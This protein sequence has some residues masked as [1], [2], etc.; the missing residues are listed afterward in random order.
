MIEP[1]AALSLTRFKLILLIETLRWCH[2]H[3][4]AIPH[5]QRSMLSHLESSSWQDSNPRYTIAA[6]I[7]VVATLAPTKTFRNVHT[8][9]KPD[10]IRMEEEGNTSPTFP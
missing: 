3:S 1:S 10:V 5:F 8:V 6:L 7:H 9:V 4:Q 2:M